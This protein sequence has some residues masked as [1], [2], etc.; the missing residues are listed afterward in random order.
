MK[1]RQSVSRRCVIPRFAALILCTSALP[2]TAAESN[3]A[4]DAAITTLVQ[5]ALAADRRLEVREPLQ[6][7][8]RGGVVELIGETE[9]ASMVYRAVETARKVEGVREVDAHR[10][11]A[12]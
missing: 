2:G 7:R 8:T 3:P 9:S 4:A 1:I 5:A 12:R 11:D 10:L 6:V